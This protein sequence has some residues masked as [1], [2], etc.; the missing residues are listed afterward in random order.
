MHLNAGT[1]PSELAKDDVRAGCGQ[2]ISEKSLSLQVQDSVLSDQLF[3][4]KNIHIFYKHTYTL[5]YVHF[6]AAHG[7]QCSL[8]SR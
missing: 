6:K 5:K 7:S 3:N 8:Q 4:Y 2:M 1:R